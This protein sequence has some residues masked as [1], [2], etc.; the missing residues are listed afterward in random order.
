MLD[1]FQSSWLPVQKF[2]SEVQLD[3][4][5]VKRKK[6]HARVC[7]RIWTHFLKEKN[8]LDGRFVEISGSKGWVM[9]S[10]RTGFSPGF[11]ALL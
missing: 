6:V 1:I 7:A 8:Q 3:L 10:I 2:I 11:M 5:K 9:G 4:W